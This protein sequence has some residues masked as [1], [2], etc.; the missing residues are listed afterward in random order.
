MVKYGTETELM[1]Y[2]KLGYKYNDWLVLVR[3]TLSMWRYEVVANYI[4]LLDNNLKKSY[5]MY[6][7]GRTKALVNI[8]GFINS[9]Q[10]GTTHKLPNFIFVGHEGKHVFV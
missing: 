7:D 2:V 9:T 5:T 1:E 3:Y 8:A 4:Q 6:I 10:S